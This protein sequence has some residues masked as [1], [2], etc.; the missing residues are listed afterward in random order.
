MAWKIEF[1]PKLE[2][3][4]KKI[5]ISE[6]KKIFDFLKKEVSANPR[7]YGKPLKGNLRE[8][9]RYRIGIHRII[10]KIDDEQMTVLVVRIGH[11]IEI[12]ENK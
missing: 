11:R 1:I 12:Y 5:P 9:W 10:V 3:Q 7:A 2:K 6:L 8:Y 4:L